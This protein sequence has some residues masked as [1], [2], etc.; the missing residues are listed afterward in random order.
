MAKQESHTLLWLNLNVTENCFSARE[1]IIEVDH[2]GKK[3]LVTIGAADATVS[4]P[5]KSL[6]TVVS[7]KSHSLIEAHGIPTF[8]NRRNIIPD[9]LPQFAS[10]CFIFDE[11]TIVVADVSMALRSN[12]GID[13]SWLKPQGLAPGDPLFAFLFRE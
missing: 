7:V 13:R 8:N 9:S 3:T 4:V 2:E 12:V 11:D 6:T 1:P 10:P 5:S